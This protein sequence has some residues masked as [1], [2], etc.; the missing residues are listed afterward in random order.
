MAVCR[1]G[2]RRREM[3]QVL[4]LCARTLQKH[5][6]HSANNHLPQCCGRKRAVANMSAMTS[7]QRSMRAARTRWPAHSRLRQDVVAVFLQRT[8][9]R[10]STLRSRSRPQAACTTAFKLSRPTGAVPAT[11]RSETGQ[12]PRSRSENQEECFTK[13]FRR[14]P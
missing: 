7:G 9:R 5:A 14:S 2:R 10:G 13:S 3:S 12:E 6:A 11:K 4:K 8:L 1:D